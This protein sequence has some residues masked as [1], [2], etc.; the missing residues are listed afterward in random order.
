MDGET[1]AIVFHIVQERSRQPKSPSEGPK[2]EPRC[3]ARLSYVLAERSRHSLIM[4]TADARRQERHGRVAFMSRPIFGLDLGTV[5][6]GLVIAPPSLPLRVLD[7]RTLV[8]DRHNLGPVADWVR[9]GLDENA[10]EGLPPD[11]VVE[12]GPLYIPAGANAAKARAMAANHAGMEALLTLIYQACPGPLYQI[13]TIARRTWSSRVVPHHRGGV[14][15]AEASAGLAAHLDPAGLWPLLSTQ[16]TRDAAGAVIGYL[17]GV[18]RR[19]VRPGSVTRTRNRKYVY[20]YVP[21]KNARTK[22]L[23]AHDARVA[24]RVEAAAAI[25]AALAPHIAHS[26]ARSPAARRALGCRCIRPHRT[27]CPLYPG[28][29]TALSHAK[30]KAQR[31]AKRVAREA[32]G[33]VA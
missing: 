29:P 24:P 3:K 27:D 9:A 6:L 11:V 13:V 15:N 8:I 30:T 22:A 2:R 32:R 14:S 1:A 7:A 12:L 19:K 21:R 33:E 10:V 4:L 26:G 25:V 31:D 17:L 18:P 23:E 20:R 5:R 16:D 28:S